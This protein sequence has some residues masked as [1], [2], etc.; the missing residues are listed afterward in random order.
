MADVEITEEQWNKIKDIPRNEIRWVGLDDG[1]L[2][3]QNADIFELNDVLASDAQGEIFLA[4]YEDSQ[5]DTII[6]KF[7]EQP[8]QAGEQNEH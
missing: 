2:L 4:G 1:T 7:R 3:Y 6:I 5:I 8:Q